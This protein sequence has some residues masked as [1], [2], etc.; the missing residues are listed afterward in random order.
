MTITTDPLARLAERL[1]LQS[2]ALYTLLVGLVLATALTL[3][4]P[5]AAFTERIIKPA[6]GGL[7]DLATPLPAASPTPTPTSSTTTVVASF[8]PDDAPV[9]AP[10]PAPVVTAAPPTTAPAPTSTEPEFGELLA[11]SRLAGRATAVAA[12]ADGVIVAIDRDD[13]DPKIVRLDRAGDEVGSIVITGRDLGG[14]PDIVDLA[15]D[16]D[17]WVVA[18]V[19]GPAAVLRISPDGEDVQEV[20]TFGD[21]PPCAISLPVPVACEP[22]TE[23]RAPAVDSVAVT[24]NGF[25]VTDHGQGVLWLVDDEG[26]ARAAQ[27]DAAL[28]SSDD[29]EAVTG[30]RGIVALANGDLLATVSASLVRMEVTS[31]SVVTEEVLDLDA[32]AVAL[33]QDAA[34][35]LAVLGADGSLARYDA[36]LTPLRAPSVGRTGLTDIALSDLGL[37]LS[38]AADDGRSSDVDRHHLEGSVQ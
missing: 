10:A 23:D 38:R 11:E 17:G 36:G 14:D 26:Q 16:A 32:A 22:A 25:A 34:G 21:L 4:G 13:A 8:E 15:V 37:W 1:G 20:A 12:V 5:P 33:D 2:G 9:V 3:T 30:L 24:A 6:A 27:I 7:G 28:R 18:L 29:D 31:D 19:N 35:A